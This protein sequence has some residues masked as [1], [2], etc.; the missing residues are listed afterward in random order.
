MNKTRQI[1][2]LFTMELSRAESLLRLVKTTLAVV[3]SIQDDVDLF[4]D[5]GDI[6]PQLIR[7]YQHNPLFT[8]EFASEHP[9][10]VLIP[11][12][13]AANL[14]WPLEVVVSYTMENGDFRTRRVVTSEILRTR[15]EDVLEYLSVL[16]GEPE[17]ELDTPMRLES[18]S[19][20]QPLSFDSIVEYIQL[21]GGFVE[22]Y[23]KTRMIENIM[24][25]P[26]LP[27]GTIINAA[28]R[29]G[30]PDAP[31]EWVR[32]PFCLCNP[33]G[34]PFGT[35]EW[36]R[37]PNPENIRE[38]LGLVRVAMPELME[39]M[40]RDE[41]NVIPYVFN[42]L[43][44]LVSDNPT[45]DPQMEYEFGDVVWP[46]MWQCLTSMFKS[47][48]MFK[49]DA[50]RTKVRLYLHHRNPSWFLSKWMCECYASFVYPIFTQV[51][52]DSAYNDT[53]STILCSGPFRQYFQEGF[54][55]K[56]TLC[57]DD[58]KWFLQCAT[59]LSSVWSIVENTELRGEAAIRIVR[60]LFKK[61][62]IPR[63]RQRA[64]EMVRMILLNA[65][66]G[67]DLS[68]AA[69]IAR[70]HRTATAIASFLTA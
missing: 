60:F 48:E 27:V 16:T 35:M 12:H 40:R 44:T 59:P 47:R 14:S 18:L 58:I 7:W 49:T 2:V 17:E 46:L 43:T 22:T 54:S 37:N 36:Y 55:K 41:H 1:P 42:S 38:L 64:T 8:P 52:P 5:T 50:E 65:S 66:N 57:V 30:I 67:D 69:G 51:R 34:K 32:N 39:C 29:T 15:Y 56:K 10:I 61:W 21:N 53:C 23:T 26:C 20:T 31:T 4:M 33:R 6:V 24:S 28:A 70:Y 63:R 11:S 68:P 9:E 13:I 62:V 25:N 45:W 19:R 3:P